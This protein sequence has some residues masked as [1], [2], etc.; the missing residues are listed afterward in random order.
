MFYFKIN[1]FNFG[2]VRFHSSEFLSQK[3]YS[4]KN[5]KYNSVID[6]DDIT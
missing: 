5:I 3:N 4:L 6:D 2:F 1:S